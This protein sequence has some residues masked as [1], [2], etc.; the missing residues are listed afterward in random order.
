MLCL[1]IKGLQIQETLRRRGHIY[2]GHPV[3]A[4]YFGSYAVDGLAIALHCVASTGS[5]VGAIERCI[6]FLGDADSTGAV[7]VRTL[8]VVL[9][10]FILS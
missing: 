4:E 10:V 3:S 8:V 1:L 6:N 2:N 7:T 9:F 5:L